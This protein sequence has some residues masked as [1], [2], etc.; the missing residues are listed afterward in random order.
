MKLRLLKKSHYYIFLLSISSIQCGNV[1]NANP[2]K[3]ELD[4]DWESGILSKPRDSQTYHPTILSAEYRLAQITLNNLLSR[5]INMLICEDNPSVTPDAIFGLKARPQCLIES[6]YFKQKLV[7]ALQYAELASQNY[8]ISD[9]TKSQITDLWLE[10]EFVNDGLETI[11][12]EDGVEWYNVLKIEN[13]FY[14]MGE[15]ETLINTENKCELKKKMQGWEGA[16]R[17]CN[18]NK[19]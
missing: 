6:D 12:T 4:V 1:S 19:H 13:Q 15:F 11:K 7:L 17:L 10:Y 14:F 9:S 8:L 18:R 3:C 16:N 5:G 2:A